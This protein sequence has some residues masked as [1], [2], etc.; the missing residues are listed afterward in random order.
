MTTSVVFKVIRWGPVTTTTFYW[1][2]LA[3]PNFTRP[4]ILFSTYSC[5][6]LAHRGRFREVIQ[7]NMGFSDHFTHPY[8]KNF[9]HVRNLGKSL[10]QFPITTILSFNKNPVGRILS[11]NGTNILSTTKSNSKTYQKVTTC[12][13]ETTVYFSFTIDKESVSTTTVTVMCD[14]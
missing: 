5:L 12:W 11:D 6:H 9:S 3:T 13:Q 4:P 2:S 7:K 14:V 1:N 10:S 8:T